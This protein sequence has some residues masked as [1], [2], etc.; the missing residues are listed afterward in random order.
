MI[1]NRMLQRLEALNHQVWLSILCRKSK[2]VKN[3][4]PSRL[5]IPSLLVAES[6]NAHNDILFDLFLI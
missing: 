3:N 4:V 6:S 2:D 5:N 1:D